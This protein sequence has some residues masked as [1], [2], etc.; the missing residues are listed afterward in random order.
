MLQRRQC[1]VPTWRGWLLLITIL[2]ITLAVG[3]RSVHGFLAVHAPLPGG[4]L[5][6]EGWSSDP[7]FEGAV[8]EYHR[9][10]YDMVCGTGGPI[11]VGSPFRR[12]KT[13][14]EFAKVMLEAMGLPAGVPHAVPAAKSKK[15]RTYASA[16]ALRS[17]LL[18]R[19]MSNVRVNVIGNGAHSRRTLLLFEKALAGVASVGITNVEEDSYDPAR[20]WMS[21]EGFR[22]VTGEWIAYIYARF[23]FFPPPP[24][25]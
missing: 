4:I 22:V 15:D 10:H 24:A 13:F 1:L 23:L 5:V 11:E 16:I 14:A 25:P 6:V 12:E 3:A 7:I 19:G 9:N 8:A 18:Q 2:G 21:S 20:W 17:W